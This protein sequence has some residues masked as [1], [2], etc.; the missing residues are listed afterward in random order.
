MKVKSIL[1]Q[2]SYK[3]QSLLYNEGKVLCERRKL[4]AVWSENKNSGRLENGRSHS[5]GYFLFT[6]LV[7]G[8]K[9]FKKKRK[10]FIYEEYERLK[11]EV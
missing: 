11:N 1:Y 7:G 9:N 10:R 2:F 6:C 4:S 8:T 5:V 3:V